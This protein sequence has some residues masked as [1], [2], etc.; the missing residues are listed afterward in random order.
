MNLTFTIESAELRLKRVL[1]DFFISVYDEKYLSSHGIEHHRRVWS[2]SKKLLGLFSDLKPYSLKLLPAKLIIASYL[3][4]IGMSVDPGIRHGNHSRDLCVRFLEQNYLSE[5]DYLDVLYSIENHDN[6]DYIGDPCTDD[7]LTLLSVAD[8]L[9]A[10]GFTGI[11]RYS[12]IY[13]TRGTD[14]AKI[15]SIIVEN[16][17]NRYNNFIKTFGSVHEIVKEQRI[18]YKILEDFFT[19]Y[20]KQLPGYQFDT[21]NPAGYCGVVETIQDLIS[22]KMSLK[23]YYTQPEKFTDDKVIRWFFNELEQELNTW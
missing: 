3:H 9:D 5:K 14:R 8:D 6:K 15:G 19:G 20:N 22:N 12:E 13:L 21:Q 2:Y 11:F 17:K 10:F 23:N 7:L 18:R 1:E 16:A 4:D